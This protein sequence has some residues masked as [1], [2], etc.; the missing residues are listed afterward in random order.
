[1]TAT[2]TP[3]IPSELALE[4]QHLSGT[5]I[6]MLQQIDA[7]EDRSRNVGADLETSLT[8]ADTAEE[9]AA[10]LS[11]HVHEPY[12]GSLKVRIGGREQTLYVGKIAHRD[13]KGPY[14][15]TSWES[16]VGSLFYS[17]ALDWTTPR[18]LKGTIQRRRQLDVWKKT[19]HGLTDL[20]DASTGGDTG[21]RET[22]LLQRLSEASRSGMRDVV[23]TLQP[24]QNDIMRA[25]AGTAVCIQGAA[26]SGK[27]TIGFH[28]L[29]WLAHSE[30]GPHQARPSHTLVLMPNQVLAHYA[31]RV[32]PSLNLQGVV[33]TTPETWA[34]GFLGLEKMEV[35]DRTLTLLLQDRDNTRRRAAWRRAKA[36]GDLR[37]FAVVRSHLHTRLQTNLERLTYQGSVEVQRSGRS[38]AITLA[39]SNSQLQ[40]LLTTVLER[41]PLEEYRPAFRAA[42]EAELL[43]Q[44]RVTHDEEAVVLRQLNVEVS[45]LIG[46]VFAGML[47]VTEARRLL[48]DETALRGAAQAHLPETMIQHLLSDPLASVAKPRRSFADVTELPL[49]LTVAALLDGLGKRNG[50]ALEPYDHILLDEAQDFAPLLYALLRRAARPGHLTA[51]GDLN[52]GLHGYKG[53][54]AWAGERC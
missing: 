45:R 12:F 53:P 47:P 42:L 22:V 35:T 9:H 5:I 33:V 6:S 44:A 3:P 7:W 30:R 18:G 1:M 50:H 46:R 20:Y 19:L 23:E 2:S 43:T 27:T 15:I 38:K 51:L 41:D 52:Q 37:M 36:L 17:H 13:L 11:V 34:L 24:E 40:K 25:P 49:M 26:G 21:A 32:L 10:L 28:R 8:L 48:Q 4:Q 39:L 54:N 29:A 16:E 31:S 14:S